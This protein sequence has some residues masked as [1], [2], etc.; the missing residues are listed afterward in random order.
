MSDYYISGTKIGLISKLIGSEFHDLMEGVC[1]ESPSVHDFFL[2]RVSSPRFTDHGEE[3][4]RYTEIM[5]VLC[6]VFPRYVDVNL[7]RVLMSIFPEMDSSIDLQVATSTAASSCR[8]S[9]D[10]LKMKDGEGESKVNSSGPL[11]QTTEAKGI[12]SS[13]FQRM[14][15]ESETP[16]PLFLEEAAFL[17]VA[18]SSKHDCFLNRVHECTY[19]HHHY[20]HHHHH[21]HQ[22]QQQPQQQVPDVGFNLFGVLKCLRDPYYGVDGV[23]GGTTSTSTSISS[24]TST[25]TSTPVHS[26]SVSSS[27]K[28]VPRCPVTHPR[29]GVPPTVSDLKVLVR[30]GKKRFKQYHGMKEEIDYDSVVGVCST[31]S[32]EDHDDSDSTALGFTIDSLDDSSVLEADEY[33]IFESSL[34]FDLGNETLEGNCNGFG[35]ISKVKGKEKRLFDGEE[36][37]ESDHFTYVGNEDEYYSSTTDLPISTKTIELRQQS[38]QVRKRPRNDPVFFEF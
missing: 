37:E 2:N 7:C 11:L 38:F 20:H 31:T 6:H 22:Q 1:K 23:G 9:S 10:G 35:E 17:F 36:R 32:C 5:T 33:D 21:H 4:L 14:N 24:T 8:C 25:L 12:V 19:N 15:I 28:E 30:S 29:K 26:P 18:L 27:M 13:G 34:L 16:L 3:S